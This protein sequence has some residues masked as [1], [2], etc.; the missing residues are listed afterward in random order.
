MKPTPVLWKLSLTVSSAR[1]GKLIR[2]LS[3][4]PRFAAALTAAAALGACGG[5]CEKKGDSD[6]NA[7]VIENFDLSE[8]F[9]G[10]PWTLI[11][12]VTFS[13]KDGNLGAGRA[14]S[15]IGGERNGSVISL[16][17]SFLQSGLGATTTAGDI[18]IV[19]RFN[20]QKTA[21]GASTRLGLQ[22]V[23]ADELRSNCFSLRIRF[24]VEDV[25]ATPVPCS[26]MLAWAP[27]GR[28]STRPVLGASNGWR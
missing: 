17:K 26:T 10:D 5:V 18:A 24:A 2:S 8:Q 21:D 19:L 15:F 13:D 7:P 27:T 22:L 1:G 16:D 25:T 28:L 4:A 11:F 12:A 20:E 9:E 6:D 3:F 23:D 14:E